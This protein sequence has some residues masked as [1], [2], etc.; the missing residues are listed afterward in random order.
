[1][2][3]PSEELYTHTTDTLLDTTLHLHFFTEH[4]NTIQM[5]P[6]EKPKNNALI[7]KEQ[8]YSMY[9]KIITFMITNDH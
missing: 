9:Y 1:M 4:K 2:M 8:L 6:T 5:N 3:H 7:R